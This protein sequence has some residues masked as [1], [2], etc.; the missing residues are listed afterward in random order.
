MHSPS[1]LWADSLL[2]VATVGGRFENLQILDRLPVYFPTDEF[3][4]D[5]KMK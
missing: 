1:F 4:L 3:R 5:D 2:F